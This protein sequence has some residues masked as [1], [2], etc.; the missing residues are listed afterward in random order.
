MKREPLPLGTDLLK[1]MNKFELKS[2]IDALSIPAFLITPEARVGFL[3]ADAVEILGIDVE[4]R[5]Y[6]SALRKPGIL[7]A[8]E[9]AGTQNRKVLAQF[10]V[11]SGGG[12]SRVFKITASPVDLDGSRHV[13]VCLEDRTESHDADQM[14]REFVANVSHELRT[15]LTALMGFIETL[16]G[17]AQDDAAARDRFLDVMAREARRMNRL[18]DDLLSLSRVEFS[19]RER[20]RDFFRAGDLIAD[21]GVTLEGLPDGERVAFQAAS[22]CEDLSIQGNRDQLRQVLGNL[23]ENALKYGAPDGEVLV[24][25]TKV[26]HDRLLRGKA[27]RIDVQDK[28]EGIAAHHLPRLTERFYRIDEHRSRE[29]G[30]TGLGL[31]IVKHIVQRH[32]GR[33][34]VVSEVGKGSCFSVVLPLESN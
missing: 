16:Q 11:S 7:E 15:P 10:S 17:P 32:R 13:L 2:L 14:R 3:N 24:C 20:P 34:D 28:G 26:D 12:G 4:D 30:G 9:Q 6:I 21:A 22:G 27:L 31:A 5:N 8:I 18:V 23:I 25:L 33:L 1:T 19:E 29:M